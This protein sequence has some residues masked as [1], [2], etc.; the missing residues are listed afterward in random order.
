MKWLVTACI[1]AKINLSKD[2]ITAKKLRWFA[3]CCFKLYG[4]KNHG[5]WRT[6]NNLNPYE[7]WL[8]MQCTKAQ[9]VW[10]PLVP[11]PDKIYVVRKCL[12]HQPEQC[13]RLQLVEQFMAPL[14]QS[15]GLWGWNQL[16]HCTGRRENL[17]LGKDWNITQARSL[18]SFRI[19]L[20]NTS[21]ISQPAKQKTMSC[22]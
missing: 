12:V 20:L 9:Y 14:P 4:D 21:S 16:V 22:R 8:S 6:I 15:S 18:G 10:L 3:L 13:T 17:V 11:F 2:A 19:H 7:G 5:Y 1:R